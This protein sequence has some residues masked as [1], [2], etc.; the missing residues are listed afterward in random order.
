M[1]PAIKCIRLY[2]NKKFLRTLSYQL[3]LTSYNSYPY[4]KL[5]GTSYKFASN[6]NHPITHLDK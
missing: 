4:F 6:V 2:V 5:Y 3:W 1:I